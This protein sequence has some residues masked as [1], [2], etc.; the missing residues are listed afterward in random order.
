MTYTVRSNN[1][2][3]EDH[4]DNAG[5]VIFTIDPINRKMTF[6]NGAVLD[7]SASSSILNLTNTVTTAAIV[8]NAVTAAKLTSTLATGFIPLPLF[9]ARLV[10]SND[11]ANISVS[12]GALAKDTVPVLER[13][14]GA[15]DKSLRIKWAAASVVEVMLGSFPLP[16]DINNAQP[17]IL[18]VLAYMA[19]ATDTPTL[20]LGYWPGIGGANGG[21]ATGTLSNAIGKKTWSVASPAAYPSMAAVTVTP[22]AHGTDALFLTAAWIEYTRL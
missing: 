9:G 20:T 6:A 11:V 5:N 13:T 4:L 21:G 1:N 19:G 2:G 7:I 3:T 16:P 18:N 17:L 12:G 22:G 14:N 10:S 15:T 8:A